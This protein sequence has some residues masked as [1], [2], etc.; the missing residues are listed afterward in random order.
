MS[1]YR[2]VVRLAA[3][4]ALNNYLSA[5]WPTL[6][7]PN[8]FDSKIEPVEDMKE[9][10][11]FPCVVVYTDYDKD[12]WSKGNRVH[13]DRLMSVTL[14][15]LIVQTTTGKRPNSY[16]L[17]TPATDSEIETSLDALEAQIFRA[18]TLGTE[19]SDAFN[20]ICTTPTNVIS[21]RG[22]STEG[23]H[24]LAA[25][26]L[27]I[28]MKAV[29]E[30]LLG[31]IPEPIERFLQRLEASDDYAERV[32][33]LR[34]LLTMSAPDTDFERVMRTLGYT[35]T[36]TAL[37]GGAPDVTVTMPENLTFHL[38]GAPP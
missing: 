18:L 35:R 20:Y 9:D 24:R 11:V 12:H 16:K 15:L 10:K 22:S 3:V 36:V 27:T 38:N 13:A 25:R 5:P 19:A 17:T 34:A 26:Q 2:A 21:R 14:E 8:I 31:N 30:P 23:G 32:P 33:D 29:R 6:A 28:E 37:L 1:G 4:S 7:G